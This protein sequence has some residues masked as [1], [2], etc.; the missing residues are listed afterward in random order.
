MSWVDGRCTC[1]KEML[2]LIMLR[3]PLQGEILNESM[4]I[5]EMP[6]RYSLQC[7][8]LKAWIGTG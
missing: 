8:T 6:M 7:V 2:G 5:V 4:T 1:V 3:Q